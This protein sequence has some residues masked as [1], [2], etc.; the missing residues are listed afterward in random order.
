MAPFPSFL[1][2]RGHGFA[3]S[4]LA[5]PEQ[6]KEITLLEFVSF[7]PP[8]QQKMPQWNWQRGDVEMKEQWKGVI[9]TFPWLF[10]S[11]ILA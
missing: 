10:S 1:L 11:Q 9:S 6:P 5:N 8:L 7:F 4:L 2:S 3:I